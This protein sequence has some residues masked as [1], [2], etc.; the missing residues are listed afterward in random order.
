M[1]CAD[2]FLAF[3][4]V[5]FVVAMIAVNGRGLQNVFI[6]IGILG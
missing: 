4:Y 6:A 1:R 5:L 2:I 3:P